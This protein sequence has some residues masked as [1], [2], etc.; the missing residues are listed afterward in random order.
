MSIYGVKEVRVEALQ[1][2][3]ERL[4]VE[5]INS[6]EIGGRDF[7]I[8]DAT[9]EVI[10]LQLATFVECVRALKPDDDWR[11]CQHCLSSF[12][13]NAFFKAKNGAIRV[14]NYYEELLKPGNSKTYK[15]IIEGHDYLSIGSVEIHDGDKLIATIG[16]KSDLASIF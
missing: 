11:D 13:Y 9:K 2:W 6:I 14:A 10:K 1:R 16:Q 7:V 5:D 3:V 15:K 12:A 4:T 8:E